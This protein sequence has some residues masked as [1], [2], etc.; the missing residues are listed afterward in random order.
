MKITVCELSDDQALLASEWHDLVAHLKAARSDFVLL[1]EMPFYPWWMSDARIDESIWNAAVA[2]H[3]DWKRRLAEL[4]TPCIGGSFPAVRAGE[5]INEGFL[6]ENNCYVPAHEKHFLPN[7]AGF[8]EAT[9]CSRGNGQFLVASARACTVGFLICT[10]LWSFESVRVY[11]K[12]GAHLVASPRSTLRATRDK[13]L[14]A[15]RAAAMV[16]GVFSVSSNRRGASREGLRFGGEGWI[17]DPDGNVLGVTS[18]TEPFLTID[19]EL[20]HAIRAKG[21]Y[22]RDVFR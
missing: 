8:W 11:G 3:Q 2:S 7:E 14:V 1:P 18:E 13:W 22:P 21:T 6:W 20:E 17:I 12:A 9:W 16:G 4:Q 19:I 15:G 5:R 10:E